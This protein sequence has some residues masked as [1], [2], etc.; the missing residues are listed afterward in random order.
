MSWID[1]YGLNGEYLDTNHPGD[2]FTTN[3]S[4]LKSQSIAGLNAIGAHMVGGNFLPKVTITGGAE[5]WTHAGG[6]FSHHSGWKADLDDTFCKPYTPAGIELV[7]FCHS[8]GYSIVHE[9][10]HWD[11]NF[12]GNDSRDKQWGAVTSDTSTESPEKP[13]ETMTNEMIILNARFE[14]MEEGILQGTGNIIEVEDENGEKKQIE[15]PE[16]IHTDG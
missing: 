3:V 12:S 5:T 8:Q 2:D 7:N 16:E 10:D 6:E 9:D 4:N 11:I 15:E 13:A 1:S 14:L